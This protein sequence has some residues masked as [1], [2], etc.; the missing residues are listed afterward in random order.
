MM[1]LPEELEQQLW[2]EIEIFEENE[3]MR[4]V[5]SV[6]RFEIAK[7]RQEGRQEEASKLFLLLLESKFGAVNQ[8]LQEKVR[9]A[10]P[11]LI[12]TWTKQIFQAKTPEDLLDS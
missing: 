5:T 7:G 12:E 8:Q 3:K 1:R 11:E 9:T 2:Q 4:Y 10:D 6:E